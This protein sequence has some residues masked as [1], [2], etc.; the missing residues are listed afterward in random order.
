MAVDYLSIQISTEEANKIAKRFY[1]VSGKSSP[2]PGELDFN[3]R[4]KIEKANYILKISRPDANREYIQYQQEILQVVSENE[5]IKCAP[6]L[7]P[8]INGDFI[9]L[10]GVK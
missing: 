3:F 2:L 9:V 8:N 1:N 5:Q 4:I 10:L 7:I 6:Q